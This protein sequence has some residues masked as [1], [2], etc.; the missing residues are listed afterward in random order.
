MEF[1]CAVID[2]FYAGN[3]ELRSVLLKHSVQVKDKALQIAENC[4]MTLDLEIVVRGAMLHDIG[5]IKCHAPDIYCFGTLPYISHGCAGSAML[6]KLGGDF[7]RYA[8]ICERHTGS[9]LTAKEIIAGSLPLAPVDLL[10]ETLEEKLIC[11][12]DKF[13]SKSGEM[14]EK[15]LPKIRKQMA[16]FGK[17]SADRFE[18]L[19]ELFKVTGD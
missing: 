19:L 4:G 16:K 2:R 7:E 15:P 13:F 11:L 12:A 9:G 10:P 6:R 3:A 5:I 14:K 1:A 17:D 18:A 8:R